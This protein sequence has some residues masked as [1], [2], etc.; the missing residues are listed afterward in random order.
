MKI[1]DVEVRIS[2]FEGFKRAVLDSIGKPPSGKHHLFLEPHKF[3]SMFTVERIRLLQAIR[4]H[5]DFG[6]VKLADLLGR[7]QEAVSRD[8]SYLKAIGLVSD[9]PAGHS[10]RGSAKPKPAAI[11]VIV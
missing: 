7:K 4:D 10:E 5:P 11:S 1:N 9:E 2:D 6:T 8:L 3:H